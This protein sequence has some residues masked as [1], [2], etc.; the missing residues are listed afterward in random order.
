[1]HDWEKESLDSIYS[2]LAVLK[3]KENYA[4]F[5]H[6][7]LPSHI[8]ASSWS[9]QTYFLQRAERWFSLCPLIPHTPSLQAACWQSLDALWNLETINSTSNT[10]FQAHEV[11]PLN[12]D[13]WQNRPVSSLSSGNG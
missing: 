10:N 4:T 7:S 2:V 5:S 12:T 11:C 6:T 9:F 13:L 3:A 8:H 1:M